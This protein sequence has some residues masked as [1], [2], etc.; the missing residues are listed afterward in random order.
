LDLA[1]AGLHTS[2][3]SRTIGSITRTQKQVQLLSRG[4]T[5]S[6]DST[7]LTILLLFVS[8]TGL[9]HCRENLPELMDY[10]ADRMMGNTRAAGPAWQYFC[11]YIDFQKWW[12]STLNC[13]RR[14]GLA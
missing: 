10:F 3:F 11:I 8:Q 1:V 5:L 2:L 14:P 12:K 13:V 7:S 9:E 4:K 6:R